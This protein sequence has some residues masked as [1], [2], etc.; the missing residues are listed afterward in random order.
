MRWYL[1]ALLALCLIVPVLAE[2]SSYIL[3][4]EPVDIPTPI[5]TLVPYIGQGDV[6]YV[7][8]TIDISG[9]LAPYPGLAYWDGFD[10][11]D[12]V[13]TYNM[14]MPDGKRSYYHFYLDPAI[15]SERLGKWMKYDGHFE[16][17]G[18]NIA[19][20]VAP[21]RA[22]NST[23]T[24]PN[25]TTVNLSEIQKQNY[26]PLNVKPAP[27][28]PEKHVADY[29]VAKGD[30]LVLPDGD[31]HVWIFGRVS[32]IYSEPSHNIT[33]AQINGLENGDYDIVFQYPGNN[34]IYDAA[35]D[36]DCKNLVPGLYGKKPVDVEGYQ[37][38]VVYAKL[39]EMLV[40][41]DDTLVKYSLQVDM[42]YITINQ[43]DEIEYVTR[44]ALNVRGYSNVKNG[45]VINVSL[46]ELTMQF[47]YYPLWY[48]EGVAVQTSRGN[49]S[50]YSVNV[51]FDYDELAADARNH[52]LT[53]RTAHG[54]QV[55][56]DFKISVMPA[57]S[58]RP[59]ATLK[60]IENRNPFIPTP[61]P[62]IVTK[63][64]TKIV[65]QTITIPVTP[66]NETVYE[67]QH[68]AQADVADSTLKFVVGAIV[69]LLI[70][71]GAALYALRVWRRL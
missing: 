13:P 69:A 70:V 37:P 19:F 16:K 71:V 32:G 68:K 50:Y 14:T 65:T 63:I 34:T 20:I 47:K 25:G 51:P 3:V 46:D 28:L 1:I 38:S 36:K 11:Y 10:M 7:G 40:G 27:L 44:S 18:N 30:D 60:Y 48:S 52:T 17:Q 56:K 59:N 45:T 41:T 12:S 35:C 43:A 33:I 26:T 2:N 22:K 49:L 6:V 64:E 67:Q 23:M 8:D 15:F 21:A 61:T 24:F 54:G 31:Y 53:A 57:D 29:V 9:V 42:P 62:E 4:G 58:Y 39:K 66:S 55:Q 5:P